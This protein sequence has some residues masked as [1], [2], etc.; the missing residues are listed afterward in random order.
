MLRRT[1]TSRRI[2]LTTA[3]VVVAALG[4]P[5]A[6]MAAPGT[7]SRSGA[8]VTFNA[9]PGTS[10]VLAIR[11]FQAFYNVR[12]NETLVAGTGCTLLEAGRLGRC[13]A[14]GVSRI[15]ITLGDGNDSVSFVGVADPASISGGDGADT[16][17]GTT[18]NDAIAGGPGPD[19]V[20]AGAGN[21]RVNVRNGDR[22]PVID[23]GAGNDVAQV[24]PKDPVAQNCEDVRGNR[25]PRR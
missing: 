24:D 20:R 15:T 1:T 16:L 4:V 12:A 23:C 6:A 21:D 2:G 9:A 5:S 19:T 11:P 7:V 18:R 25:R 8:T 22:D 13:G 3:L 17:G 14:L 10:D